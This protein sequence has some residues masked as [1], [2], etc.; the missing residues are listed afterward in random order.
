MIVYLKF[1]FL[2]FKL[3]YHQ[4]LRL[5]L[6]NLINI[7][8]NILFIHQIFDNDNS[9]IG[10]YSGESFRPPIIYTNG[11]IVFI[12]FSARGDTGLGYR[13]KIK[14]LSNTEI[15]ERKNRSTH[16]GGLVEIFGG[17][18]TMMNMID[19]GIEPQLYDC[20]WIIKPPISYML[21]KTH[22]LVRVDTFKEMGKYDFTKW[23]KINIDSN[24]F[25][26]VFA[27]SAGK[28]VIEIR[29]GV[30]STNALLQKIEWTNDSVE[31]YENLIT[32]KTNGFYISFSGLF[33][34]RSKFAI[35]F[36]AFSYMGKWFL[37]Y[38]QSISRETI[39]FSFRSI[40]MFCWSG[41]SL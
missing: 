3:V 12:R 7:F 10:K 40:R 18:I 20:I 36:T 30:A 16:C 8:I 38:I 39:F 11:S 6:A 4:R 17:A 14:T 24:I 41:I 37:S 22:L 15:F 13:G 34:S 21:L 29:E 31:T 33:D 5:I 35:V 25:F 27:Y 26:F 2:T 32:T 19:E 1:N 28:S 23:K 9:S